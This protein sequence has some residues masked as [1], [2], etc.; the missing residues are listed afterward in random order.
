M[1]K[2]TGIVLTAT[3]ISFV[4][5][6]VNTSKPNFRVGM[7][8]LGVA[9]LFDGLEKLNEPAAVGLSVIMLITVVLTPINGNSP[10]DTVLHLLGQPVP[11]Q[12]TTT[13]ARGVP[14]VVRPPTDRLV[15]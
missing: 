6:W 4:N 7:A 8:G 1:A 2:S 10:A 15:R 12:D 5:E 3:A 14:L 11:G 13:G 9:L